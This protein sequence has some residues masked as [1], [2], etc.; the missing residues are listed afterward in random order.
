[1]ESSGTPRAGGR[2][3]KATA[4][5][6][7]LQRRLGSRPAAAEAGTVPRRERTA[8][9]TASF[10]QE[11]MWLVEQ[12]V[13]GGS[14]Y[15]I[16]RAFALAGELDRPA[17]AAALAT[18]VARHEALRTAFVAFD[19]RPHLA[20]SD[21][22]P[23]LPVAD[24][25][26]LPAALCPAELGRLAA[27]EVV[28]TFD[29]GRPPLLRATLVALAAAEHALLL[30]LHHIAAD[31]WSMDLLYR[32]LA[33][34]YGA[35]AAGGRPALPPLPVGYA[36]WAAWQR[37]RLAGAELERLLADRRRRLDGFPTVLPLPGDRPRPAAPSFR[38]AET[39][40]ALPP[41]TAAL[42]GH[43]AE[44]ERATPF[45]VLLAAWGALL[46]RF[47]GEERLLVGTPI[48]GR[49]LSETEGLVGLFVNT[50]ALPVDLSGDP[51]FAELVG[52]VRDACL[53]AYAAQELPFER[54]V[55]ALAPERSLARSPLVQ[56]TFAL[57][58][59]S[60]TELAL[61]GLAVRRL[62]LARGEAIFD[63]ELEA[64]DGPAG[65]ALRLVHA[66]DLF[67]GAT[68]ARLLDRFALLLAGALT[69]HE[70]RLSDLPL[71]GPAERQQL[72]EWND[73]RRPF[74][75]L[76]VHEL[77]HE[78]VA[79]WAVAAPGAVAV[80]DG[81]GAA[82]TYAELDRAAG[83]LARHLARLGVGPEARVAVCL[84]RGLDLP[85]ALLAV[86]AAGG[87]YL[88]LDPSWP[89]ER[90][91]QL[92]ADGDARLLITR[93]SLL[94]HLAGA[95][96][97]V[98]DLD[99][100]DD[101][102]DLDG[103][104]AGAEAA[105]PLPVRAL[106]ESAAYVLYT[107]GSTG[108]PKGTLVP[109]A[110]L[111]NLAAAIAARYGLAAGDRVLQFSSFAF[112][113]AAEEIYPT[114]ATG[115]T[116]VMR[117]A[118]PP[119]APE[120]LSGLLARERIT[121]ANLPATMWHAWVAAMAERGEG[122]PA[123]LRLAVTGS[124]A[125]LPERLVAWRALAGDRV[126]LLNAYGL[127][128]TTVTSTVWEPPSAGPMVIGAAA[129]IGR[130]L[131]N[132]RAW[133]LDRAL[134]P[135]PPGTPG[136]LWL[137]GAGIARGYLGRPDLT[138]ERFAPSPPWLEGEPGERLYRTGDLARWLPSGD[139]EFL[140]RAD[141]QVKLRG[142]RVEP[143]EI[144][145]ALAAHPG[146]SAAAVV[147][148]QGPQ[149]KPE[150]EAL[151][152]VA[153][154]VAAAGSPPVADLREHLRARLPEH[155]VPAAVVELA[156]LP[157]T[158]SGKID[159]RALAALGV[160]AGAGTSPEAHV[161]AAGPVEELLAEVFRE[162]LGVE[163]VGARD[164]FFALGGH[165]LAAAQVVAR[166][167][168][169]LG[170]ELPLRRLF[171]APTVAG[172][173]AA[174]ATAERSAAPP[175][176]PASRAT[177]LPLSFAQERL[178]FLDRLEPGS[179]AYN[180][181]L[182]VRLTGSLTPAVVAA[183]LG[184]VVRRH[185]ALRTTFATGADGRPMQVVGPPA[186]VP[187][188]VV[189]ATGLDEPAKSLEADR[190]ARLEA[191]R[192]FDLERGPVLR[193]AL[194]RLGADEHLLLATVHHVAG[195]GWSAGIVLRE[196]T[197]AMRAA[198][199][200]GRPDLPALPVQYADYAVWQ[201][202]WLA[203]EALDARLAWWRERLAGMPA[204]LELPADRPRPAVARHRGARLA[205]D[206]PAPL[207]GAIRDLAR[208][209]G[210]TAFMVLLAAFQAL[211]GRWTG[212]ADPPVGTPVANRGS[213]EVEGLVGFFANTLVL[214]S[215]LGGDPGFAALLG[216]VREACLGAWAHQ[217]LPFE[218]LVEALAPERALA[219]TP[220]FQV[221]FTLDRRPAA[222]VR[223][224]VVAELID[225]DLGT[226]KFDLSLGL[227]EHAGRLTGAAVYDRDLFDAATV[228]RLL[229]RKP[230]AVR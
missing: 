12:L 214:R 109:H 1:M 63:L 173:A 21:A 105:A 62:P 228:E 27:R 161:P 138:A 119:P 69:R 169:L 81:A 22:A 146:V 9:L 125:V 72:L 68:A 53:A 132:V 78:A 11:R 149:R 3:P 163:R 162:V 93:S 208:R 51:P 30:T 114:W 14:A 31:G 76:L 135:A 56:V 147:A 54:L 223:G 104:T 10:A 77:V 165:S 83:R 49:T 74:P 194:L 177:A 103:A 66:A 64:S 87:A 124:E 111:A 97:P 211:L 19:G 179:A 144:E 140:G 113:V 123:G 96:V 52:R 8:P 47:S 90:L 91:A 166:V 230:V 131:A 23:A 99:D 143:G 117:P 38:G 42:V 28:R 36:D 59:A 202:G 39:R 222:A 199:A 88:P 203:G 127:T 196:L 92:L 118:G 82:L 50:L 6:A 150:G 57:Q 187:L 226:S 71:L 79:A 221:L 85:V 156:A 5:G 205:L 13:P 18:V 136:E 178:W 100:L 116:V 198:A 153:F 186:P 29:L 185:E 45:M 115:G 55:E 154:V 134:K 20:L 164:D 206:L 95:G 190:L 158:P 34:A 213:A 70:E 225:V 141:A 148:T 26:G 80:E 89:R 204:V 216:R 17:L 35:L 122:P 220:L 40:A 110:A 191:L 160:A 86:L 159:R 60:S 152:L 37:E 207:S 180:L 61:P 167:R 43:T 25:A 224:G 200:G 172:L 73:T 155:L 46:G 210:A 217:D 128:E 145:A 181:P 75:S 229:R 176:A 32:E 192:P 151:R 33:A 126:R 142:F 218:R 168:R 157:L 189:D 65:L 41:P 107:S 112:D 195:D 84:E 183:A 58:N 193:A 139:L 2:Q 24:L 48:A 98:V 182:P 184:E 174:V 175:L 106:P 94:P 212:R 101:L 227:E 15:H 16:A 215:D 129:P 209:E 67:D 170:V 197:E 7:L 120:E 171:E 133:V 102:Y 219:A 4:I 188:P 44:R 121:V 137:G 201:R 130:P 108:R